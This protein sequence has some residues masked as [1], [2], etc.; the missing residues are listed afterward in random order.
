MRKFSDTLF[1]HTLGTRLINQL[2]FYYLPQMGKTQKSCK[3]LKYVPVNNICFASP[4]CF[5][6]KDLNLENFKQLKL[7]L[8]CK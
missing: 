7:R 4:S 3:N 2:E 6:A 5:E 1:P 8:L